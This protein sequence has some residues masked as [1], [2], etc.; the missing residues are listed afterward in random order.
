M[1]DDTYR[2]D[3]PQ[4]GLLLPMLVLAGQVAKAQQL[5]VDALVLS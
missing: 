2:D 3:S 4:G 5:C 1:I